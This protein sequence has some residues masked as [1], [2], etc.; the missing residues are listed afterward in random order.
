MF[1]NS[2][3]I[4]KSFLKEIKDN[5][6]TNEGKKTVDCYQKLK[7][8]KEKEKIHDCLLARYIRKSGIKQPQKMFGEEIND[9]MKN[10]R[11]RKI[12]LNRIN[13]KISNILQKIQLHQN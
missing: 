9:F 7:D 6:S 1:Y 5:Y 11:L 4:T 13:I 2:R 12:D 10:K 3:R 8:L